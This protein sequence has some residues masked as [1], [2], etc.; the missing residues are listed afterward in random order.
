MLTVRWRI[1]SNS[2]HGGAGFN[3]LTCLPRLYFTSY[4][5]PTER[6]MSI[7][8]SK[9]HIW[10]LEFVFRFLFASSC[11]FEETMLLSSSV[12]RCHSTRASYLFSFHHFVIKIECNI[13]MNLFYRFLGS[14]SVLLKHVLLSGEVN[15]LIDKFRFSVT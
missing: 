2:L 5:T 15:I 4:S 3:V 9:S 11:G 10:L 8:V 7:V 12:S 1:V 6:M 13:E 14:L